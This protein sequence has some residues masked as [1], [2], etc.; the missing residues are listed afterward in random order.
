MTLQAIAPTALWLPEF[1]VSSSA[2]VNSMLIDAAGEKAAYIIAA[3]KAGTIDK[4]GFRTGVVTTGAWT[5][6]PNKMSCLG[7]ILTA[8]DDGIGGASSHGAGK[9]ISLSK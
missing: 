4:V 9:S 8:L 2:A 5:D 7:L 6:T 3:P 1:G